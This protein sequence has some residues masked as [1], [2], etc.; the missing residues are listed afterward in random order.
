M[1]LEFSSRSVQSLKVNKFYQGSAQLFQ[2]LRIF[3]KNSENA[4]FP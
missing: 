2:G 1:L 3:V 4:G